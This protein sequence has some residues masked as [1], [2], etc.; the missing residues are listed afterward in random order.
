MKIDFKRLNTILEAKAGRAID[1]LDGLKCYSPEFQETLDAILLMLDASK[2]LNTY[3]TE[4]P[5]CKQQEEQVKPEVSDR[6][7]PMDLIGQEYNSLDN[8]LID[9]KHV[10]LF[11]SNNCG[12]CQYLVPI[13]DEYVATHN[14]PL[15]K[16]LLDEEPGR[17]QAQIHKVKGWP[18]MFVVENNKV[19]NVM[20]GADMNAPEEMT[21][22]RIDNELGKFFI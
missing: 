10:V 2:E 18:T 7:D 19:I 17:S 16:I 22:Q 12:P 5:D 15:E 14:I 6:P 9:K 21:K 3:D 11:Y 13:L 4:C 1:R 20:V 8:T